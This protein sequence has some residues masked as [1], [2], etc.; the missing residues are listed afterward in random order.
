MTRHLRIIWYIRINYHLWKFEIV[1][2]KLTISVTPHTNISAPYS[3]HYQQGEEN[4]IDEEN[5]HWTKMG[6]DWKIMNKTILY[7]KHLSIF[8]TIVFFSPLLIKA[9]HF[10][11]IHHEHHHISFSDKPSM[12]SCNVLDCLLICSW[13]QFSVANFCCKE[14]RSLSSFAMS[15]SRRLYSFCSWYPSLVFVVAVFQFFFSVF[16]DSLSLFSDAHSHAS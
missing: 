6:F 9:T 2:S 4:G 5:K 7:R 8:L 12:M 16:G 15:L 13:S 1:L 3:N 11:Y 10:L 14:S